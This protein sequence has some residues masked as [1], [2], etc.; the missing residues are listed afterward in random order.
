MYMP[1]GLPAPFTAIPTCDSSMCSIL[2][3]PPDSRRQAATCSARPGKTAADAGR[4]GDTRQRPSVRSA[5]G[6]ARHPVMLRAD[7]VAELSAR[8]ALPL[9]EPAGHSAVSAGTCRMP[10]CMCGQI[11]RNHSGVRCVSLIGAPPGLHG[12]LVSAVRRRLSGACVNSRCRMIPASQGGRQE[13]AKAGGGH[14]RQEVAQAVSYN[15]SMPPSFEAAQ[16]S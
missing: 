5:A 12:V 9:A 4:D 8:P 1:G 15:Q 14:S 6:C 16:G 13:A 11:A 10:I 2:T 3:A 7:P